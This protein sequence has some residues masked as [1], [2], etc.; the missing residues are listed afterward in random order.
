MKKVL[1]IIAASCLFIACGKEDDQPIG[2]AHKT[3]GNG[4]AF[5]A[6]TE[7]TDNPGTKLYSDE[8][9]KLLWNADD[10]ISIFNKRTVND[11]YCFT[12]NDG[13]NAGGFEEVNP[14]GGF[15][16]GS[17]LDHIYAVYPYNASTTINNAGTKITTTLPTEQTYLEHSFG[18]GANTMVAVTDD[19]F[20]TFKN[21]CG[22]LALRF[23]GHSE[24]FGDISISKITIKGNNGE[25][26]AGDATIS[27]STDNVPVVSMKETA[28]D[29]ISLVCTTPVKIGSTKNDYTEFII[30]L[31]PVSFSNGFTIT[32]TESRGCIFK[33]KTQKSLTISRNRL[34]N[35]SALEVL[36][37][38]DI[39]P[40][41]FSDNN[42]KTYCIAMFDTN[43]DNKLSYAEAKAVTR[44]I[45]NNF[46]GSFTTA[47]FSEFEN[48][49]YL[50]WRPFST[51]GQYTKMLLVCKTGNLDTLICKKN[52]LESLDVTGCS[53][54]KYLECSENCL[55]SLDVSGCTSLEKLICYKNR[56]YESTG[57]SLKSI[58]LNG[59]N[60]LKYLNCTANAI[61]N[62]GIDLSS[63]V[64][65]D[66]LY[67]E[68]N[69]ISSLDVSNS[70]QLLKLCAWPQ[71]SSVTLRTL[72]MKSEQSF[73]CYYNSTDI[74]DGG[75]IYETTPSANGTQIIIVD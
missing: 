47:D 62:S 5:Y 45:N 20:L 22:Y 32:V 58:N 16:S 40:I 26:I 31:P 48:L 19:Y 46:S 11:Q 33:K 44:I 68:Q 24:K 55:K 36:P 70:P 4:P 52:N 12:G 38:F 2:T 30:T 59:C 18:K 75:A 43:H 35:M 74:Y 42:F 1:L 69:N 51:L 54:L 28:I 34:E 71:N 23:Y 39:L 15:V 56:I 10:R 49:K 64:A 67:C 7:L 53:S 41:S 65:L 25:K 8:A 72:Y 60:S 57:S 17:K 66:E 37:D 3:A 13:D 29:S 50:E 61:S 73:I 9:L 14:S 21:A 6:T 63:L 27:F